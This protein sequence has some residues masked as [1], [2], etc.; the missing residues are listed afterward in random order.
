MNRVQIGSLLGLGAAFLAVP[1]L[2]EMFGRTLDTLPV[3]MATLLLLLASLSYDPYIA[4]GVFMVTMAIYA[5]HHQYDLLGISGI[6]D[7]H[8]LSS[9]FKTPEATVNLN[10]GG[11]SDEVHEPVDFMPSKQVQDNTASKVAPSINEKE[12]LVSEPLGSKAEGIFSE[13]T[14]K[15]IEHM[16]NSSR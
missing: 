4:L 11:Q 14:S 16:A 10:H 3:R 6:G 7:L 13:E 5:Q 2:A 9:A 12:V 1:Q 15:N 8:L